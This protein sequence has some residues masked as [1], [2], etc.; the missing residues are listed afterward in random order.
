MLAVGAK[1]STLSQIYSSLGYSGLQAQHVN[2]GYEHLIHMLGHSQDA[3]QL[4]A[5]AGVSIR[6]G[7]KVVDQFLEGCSALL[8]KRSLQVDFSKPEIAAEEINKFIAKK[9]QWQDY[10]HGEGPEPWYGDD[11]D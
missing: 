1:G 5:G 7:F 2:E 9:N 10:Q 11:A 6:E 3:M 8:Q 4:E